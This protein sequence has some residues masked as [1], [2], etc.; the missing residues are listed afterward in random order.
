MTF[1]ELKKR[2]SLQQPSQ[3]QTTFLEI[4]RNKPFWIWDKEEHKQTDILT[5]GYCCFNH[6]IGLPTKDEKAMP[7]FDY[8]KIIFNSL[9][10]NK[11]VWIR[12]YF[13]NCAFIYFLKLSI[14]FFWSKR[15]PKY[16]LFPAIIWYSSRNFFR[17]LL[18]LLRK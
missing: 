11:H 15:Y 10:E 13:L 17:P 16:L 18:F 3:Q 12:N 2:F 6:V 7:L 1:K 4:L 5:N 14:R 9:E 8:E